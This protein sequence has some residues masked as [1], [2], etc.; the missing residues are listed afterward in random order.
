[1]VFGG[2]I[3]FSTP[4][5]K[6]SAAFF[7]FKRSEEPLFFGSKKQKSAFSAGVEEAKA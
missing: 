1:M 2:Q 6:I 3:A 5:K 7:F 4:Q